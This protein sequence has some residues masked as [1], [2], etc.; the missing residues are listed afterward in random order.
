LEDEANDYWEKVE[1]AGEENA[2]Q[3]LCRHSA[4]VYEGKMLVFGGTNDVVESNRLHVYNLEER[5][6]E[7]VQP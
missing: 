4:V 3:E 7:C 5:S 1:T 6:W 2:P